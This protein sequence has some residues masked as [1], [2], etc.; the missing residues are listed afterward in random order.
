MKCLTCGSKRIAGVSA[1]CSDKFN[2]ICHA[3][4]VDDY[5]GYVLCEMNIGGDDYIE[6]KY[7]LDCGQMLGEWPVIVPDEAWNE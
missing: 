1:K 6:F 4:G 5:C 2:M 3:E 7:C